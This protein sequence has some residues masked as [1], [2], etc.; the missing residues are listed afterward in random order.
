MMDEKDFDK[1]S[2]IV[3]KVGD[4]LTE[5]NLEVAVVLSVLVSML[6]STALSQANM[7]GVQL[8]RLLSQAVEKYEDEVKL[9]E[10]NNV[11]TDS[12]TTH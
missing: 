8:L 3:D 4:F 6:V 9:R 11:K 10:E 7:S 12:R 2:Q 1:A 5:E